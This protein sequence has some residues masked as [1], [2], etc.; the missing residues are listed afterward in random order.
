MKYDSERLIYDIFVRADTL[1]KSSRVSTSHNA[2]M[3]LYLAGVVI[4]CDVEF[5]TNV[6]FLYNTYMY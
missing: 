2:C 4:V 6:L 3:V 1:L 5:Y